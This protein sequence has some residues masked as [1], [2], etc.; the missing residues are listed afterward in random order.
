MILPILSTWTPCLPTWRLKMKKILRGFSVI[1]V[2]ALAFAGIMIFKTASQVAKIDKSPVEMGAVKDGTYTGRSESPLVKVEVEVS[3]NQGQ[4][5]D[6]QILGHQCGQGEKAEDIISVI[7]DQNTVEVDAISGAT[8]SS[9]LIK[10][11][12][13]KALRA[14]L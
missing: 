10:D 11:A 5:E 4:I 1:M 7:L 3:V 2:L 12:V 6:I 8:V 14:G 9:E 13:R